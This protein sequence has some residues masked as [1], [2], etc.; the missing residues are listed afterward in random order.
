MD[1]RILLKGD[2]LLTF[3]QQRLS[4][5]TIYMIGVNSGK[6]V[7]KQLEDTFF[8]QKLLISEGGY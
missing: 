1:G 5:D 4:A 2:R 7:L 3:I 8:I 6:L